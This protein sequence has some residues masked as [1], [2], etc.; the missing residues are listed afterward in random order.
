MQGIK[1]S[2]TIGVLSIAAA[3]VACLLT[4]RALNY[5]REVTNQRPLSVWENTL[6]WVFLFFLV[7]LGVYFTLIP[8]D[9]DDE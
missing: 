9:I 6:F 4:W 2:W 7:V 5:A 3:A 1:K 8:K